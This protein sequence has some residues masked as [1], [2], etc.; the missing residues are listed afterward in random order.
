[1]SF[2]T[3]VTAVTFPAGSLTGLKVRRIY[4]PSLRLL[5]S[6]RI[7]FPV[8]N[9]WLTFSASSFVSSGECDSPYVVPI[10]WSSGNPSRDRCLSLMNWYLQSLSTRYTE[11]SVDST[12]ERYTSSFLRSLHISFRTLTCAFIAGRSS[13]FPD[14][15]L[16]V[17]PGSKN[18]PMIFRMCFYR[19]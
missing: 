16:S 4:L 11:S 15:S 8:S 1:M 5:C 9:T 18:P 14:C 13:F 12:N 3:T 6:C 2:E 17:I 19:I 7:D 10:T